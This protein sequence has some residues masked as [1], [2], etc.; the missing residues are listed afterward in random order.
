M[1]FLLCDDNTLFLERLRQKVRE[2]LDADG[3]D[4]AVYVYPLPE[5]IPDAILSCCDVFFLDIDFCCN[6]RNGMDLAR[7]IRKQNREAIIVFVTNY[8]EYAPEGY[9][10]SAFRY[11]LKKDID[12][13]LKPCLQEIFKRFRSIQKHLIV[14]I[15]GEMVNIKV[16]DIVFVEA[17]RHSV[18]IHTQKPARP[19]EKTYKLYSSLSDMEQH[20]LPFGFLRIQKS[21]LANL[22]RITKLNC[23][24]ATFDNGI[25]LR[26]S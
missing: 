3:I 11:L 5:E 25:S 6:P 9:E 26:I 17:D 7:T 1:K 24:E 10:V 14:N 18:I 8:I 4:A 16:S 20:L 22:S 12:T 19:K 15:S 23:Q 2:I 13:T 21:Y